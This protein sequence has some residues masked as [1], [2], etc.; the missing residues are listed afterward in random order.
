MIRGVY[1]AAIDELEIPIRYSGTAMGFA[2]F[3]GF[4]PEA[5]IY[6]LIGNWMDNYPGIVG[7]Q[8]VFTYMICVTAVGF[9]A[10][11][12]LY[13]NVKKMKADH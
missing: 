7:Y 3:L 13:K 8:K 5:Y 9:I 12:L 2:S 11:V 10:S 6:T 1:F 4:I